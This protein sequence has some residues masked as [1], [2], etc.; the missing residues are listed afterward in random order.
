MPPSLS[1]PIS[2]IVFQYELHN[3]EIPNS[4]P[5]FFSIPPI[6]DN[7][8][9]YSLLLYQS[10]FHFVPPLHIFER[11]VHVTVYSYIVMFFLENKKKLGRPV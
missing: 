2:L 10:L 9:R 6:R 7:N 11:L 4:I 1:L 8:Q 5:V 3:N